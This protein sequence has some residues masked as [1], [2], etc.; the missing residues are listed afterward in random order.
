ML[1]TFEKMIYY[2][3]I[4][5]LAVVIVFSTV[6]LFISLGEGVFIDSPYRLDHLE[7]LNIFGFFL[8]VLIG[9]EILDT[10]K[11]YIKENKIHV[12]IIV[13]LAVIAVAR[14]MIL[15]DLAKIADFT[16]I[17]IGVVFISLSGGYYLIK[18]VGVEK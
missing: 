11:A 6:E 15:L 8:L 5:L 1:N 2:V 7:L 10:I 18:K 3:L 16:L 4:S 14:Q 17:G 13:L 12:E 9:I